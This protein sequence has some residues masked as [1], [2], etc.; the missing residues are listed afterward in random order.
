MLYN[1]LLV[2]CNFVL[3]LIMTRLTTIL[4]FYKLVDFLKSSVFAKFAHNGK[5]AQTFLELKV[6]YF[7][8]KIIAS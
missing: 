1:N 7:C 2:F 4:S 5:S 3:K 6:G 8:V